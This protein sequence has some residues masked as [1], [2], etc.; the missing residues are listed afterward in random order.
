MGVDTRYGP[1]E[2]SLLPPADVRDELDMLQHLE[3]MYRL[4]GKY[5]GR[6]VVLRSDEPVS[7]TPSGKLVNVVRVDKLMDAVQYVNV[8]TQTVGVYPREERMGELRDRMG[9]SGAQRIVALGE[10]YGGEPFGGAPHDATI[11][12]NKFMRWAYETGD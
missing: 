8:A 5:D 12:I 2:S 4:F 9:S 7:F 11:P 3:P 1:G 6:G 10:V